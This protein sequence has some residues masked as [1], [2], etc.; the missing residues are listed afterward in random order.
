MSCQKHTFLWAFAIA[1]ANL[2][3]Q[4]C[5]LHVL[6]HLVLVPAFHS[7]P[8]LIESCVRV[9]IALFESVPLLL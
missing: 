5:M 4:E 6:V 1:A 8:L 7:F 9:L 3:A 2:N